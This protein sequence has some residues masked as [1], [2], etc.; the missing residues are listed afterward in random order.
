MKETKTM[1][2]NDIWMR[3]DEWIGLGFRLPCPQ[4]QANERN[5]CVLFRLLKVYGSVRFRC[6]F[7][8]LPIVESMTCM[9]TWDHDWS[10]FRV[11][12]KTAAKE[13]ITNRNAFRF[14]R[15]IENQTTLVLLRRYSLRCVH[16]DAELHEGNRKWT[17]TICTS[18]KLIE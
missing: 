7:H 12:G 16:L 2:T 15:D 18:N 17:C 14:T 11:M 8:T 9:D 10:W 6:R 4:L 1:K 5:S 3:M 13:R